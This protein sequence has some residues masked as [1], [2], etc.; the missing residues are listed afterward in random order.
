MQCLTAHKNASILGGSGGARSGSA[1]NEGPQAG[2]VHAGPQAGWDI[3]PHS[4]RGFAPDSKPGHENMPQMC[5]SLLG[6]N[7]RS[8]RGGAQDEGPQAGLVHAGPQAGRTLAALHLRAP[9][10]LGPALYLHIAG[11]SETVSHGL[12]SVITRESQCQGDCAC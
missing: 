2:L 12:Y 9:R 6:S 10:L 5:T 3:L 1:Q 4:K 11:V 7:S 8:R